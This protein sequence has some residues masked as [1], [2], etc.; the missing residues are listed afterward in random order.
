[1]EFCVLLL[2]FIFLENYLNYLNYINYLKYKED[3]KIYC[4]I[5]T[6]CSTMR[7]IG[8]DEKIDSWIKQSFIWQDEAD[9]YME[10]IRNNVITNID[11]LEVSEKLRCL[12]EKVNM[13]F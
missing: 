4:Q 11:I 13:L 8:T 7:K 10:I 12:Y 2:I 1:M 5:Y 3:E 6:L 9:K